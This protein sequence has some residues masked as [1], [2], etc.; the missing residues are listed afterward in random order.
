MSSVTRKSKTLTGCGVREGTAEGGLGAA[1]GALTI[2]I[3]F[4]ISASGASSTY[5][6]RG[7]RDAESEPW[8]DFLGNLDSFPL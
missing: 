6:L 7:T 4:P 2:A 3:E 1:G 8:A 5:A